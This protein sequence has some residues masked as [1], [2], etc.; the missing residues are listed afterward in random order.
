MLVEQAV[1]QI[2]KTDAAIIALVG[3]RIFYGVLDQIV[4][5]PAIAYRPPAAGNRT[6]I[7]TMQGGCSLVSQRVHVYSASKGR[8][9]AIA[10]Q[11]ALLDAAVSK[12]LDEYSGTIEDLT[13][14][15]S[16]SITIQAIFSTGLA[17][18]YVYDDPQ[19]V[20]NFLTEFEIHYT[21]PQRL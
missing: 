19:Q 8:G 12:A 16:E 11:A 18:R 17:H 14:S 2:L 5:Y 13:V 7:R 1:Y 3:S 6:L 4:T 10:Q 20:H 15:P 21:D 9:N